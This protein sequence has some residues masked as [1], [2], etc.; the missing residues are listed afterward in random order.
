MVT[1][2]DAWMEADHG[3]ST[4]TQRTCRTV[5]NQQVKPAFGQ[6]CIREVTPVVGRSSVVD[7]LRDRATTGRAAR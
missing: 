2:A 5:I 1:L 4:G 6:L 3:W 7:D